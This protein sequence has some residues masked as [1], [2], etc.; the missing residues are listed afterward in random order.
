M[1]NESLI[2][3]VIIIVATVV[4]G[5]VSFMVWRRLRTSRPGNGIQMRPSRQRGP[6]RGIRERDSQGL[7]TPDRPPE[8]F[9]L[10]DIL[11]DAPGRPVEGTEMPGGRSIADILDPT[12]RRH[13]TQSAPRL[14]KG[15]KRDSPE[16]SQG[17]STTADAG[18]GS[19][20][21]VSKPITPFEKSAAEA[22]RKGKGK[23]APRKIQRPAGAPESS[24]VPL[25]STESSPS[26]SQDSGSLKSEQ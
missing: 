3:G 7:H 1:G 20:G 26:C 19:Q 12:P 13:G 8:G 14:K 18:S 24:D 11:R 22:G 10:A 16:G 5:A 2:I 15:K 6:D 4:G 25:I 21:H 17:G 9:S 23:P